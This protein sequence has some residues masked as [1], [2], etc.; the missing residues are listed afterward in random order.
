MNLTIN[1]MDLLNDCEGIEDECE[2]SDEI[3]IVIVKRMKV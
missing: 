2:E 3:Q 1:F